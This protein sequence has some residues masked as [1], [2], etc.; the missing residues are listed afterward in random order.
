MASPETRD[1]QI[2]GAS[3]IDAALRSGAPI[4]LILIRRDTED[5]AVLA[6]VKLAGEAGIRVRRVGSTVLGRVSRSE[7]PADI[8]ALVGRAPGAGLDEVLAATGAVWLLAGVTYPSNAGMAI[9]TAEVS[10]ADGII[11]DADFDAAARRFALR[12]SVRSDWYMPVLWR[13]AEE[14]LD[15]AAAAGR[16]IIG[17][18]H[19]G[20]QAPWEVDL[21]GR[22]LFVVGGESDGIPPE[23]LERC[24]RI[25]RIPMAGFIP[26]YNLQAAIAAVAV[27]RLRQS[28]MLG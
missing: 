23:V 6:V 12:I 26:S 24:H 10:G 16:C 20:T 2:A 3:Q 27:E 21:T 18:E 7:P 13:R 4:E 15:V 5:P 11:I 17:I 14:V 19:V 28:E 8:L 25:V 9:R 1:R 22:A